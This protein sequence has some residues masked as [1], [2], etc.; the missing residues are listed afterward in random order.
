MNPS[1]NPPAL[2]REEI[3][4]QLEQF[5]ILVLQAALVLLE[6]PEPQSE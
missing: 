1:H 5:P 6:I 4:R 2:P 3:I